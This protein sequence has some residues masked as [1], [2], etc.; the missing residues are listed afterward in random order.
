VP[1]ADEDIVLETRNY[2][3]HAKIL[4]SDSGNIYLVSH[5]INNLPCVFLRQFKFLPFNRKFII[6]IQKILL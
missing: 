3:G 6:E 1:V 5:R 2:G 4:F